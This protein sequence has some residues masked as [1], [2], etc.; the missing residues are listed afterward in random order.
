MSLANQQNEEKITA[1]IQQRL[2]FKDTQLKRFISKYLEILTNFDKLN[3]EQLETSSKETLQELEILEFQI[4]KAEM[5]HYIRIK[6]CNYYQDLNAEILSEVQLALKD[7]E[8]AKKA[9]ELE[10]EKKRM[11]A[12]YDLIAE[13]IIKYEEKDIIN[14]KVHTGEHEIKD[15]NEE[16]L[17]NIQK[18]EIKEK[19]LYLTVIYL[20]FYKMGYFIIFKEFYLNF[21]IFSGILKKIDNIFNLLVNFNVFYYSFQL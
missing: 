4:L 2:A 7:I 16:Y 8:S 3:A 17:K 18:I 1:I 11:K 5:A 13:E 12:E 20:F 9:L 19:E 14:E 10:G 15:L 21:Y 6:D